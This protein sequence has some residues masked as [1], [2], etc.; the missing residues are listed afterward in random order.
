MSHATRL[1]AR[2]G[3]Q[4]GWAL[5]TALILMT[6]M[7]GASLT[8]V[9]YMDNET[10][11]GKVSRN[12]ETA[13]NLGEGALNAQVLA[14][15]QVW[16]GQA[17]QAYGGCTNTSTGTACPN[18]QQLVGRFPTSDAGGAVWTT[19]VRDN[20]QPGAPNFYSDSGTASAPGYD[21]NKDGLLWVR[22]SATA[23]GKTRTMVALVRAETQQEDSY[24]SALLS[25]RVD[26]QNNGNQTT[27]NDTGS[28][29]TVRCTPVDGESAPCAGYAYPLSSQQESKLASQIAPLGVTTGY[30]G[31][32]AISADAVERLKATAISQGNYYTSCPASLQGQLVGQIVYVD[33]NATCSYTGNTSYNTA[34][35]PGVLIMNQGTLSLGGGVT[36]YGIVYHANTQGTSST[37]VSLTGNS[38]VQGSVMVEGAGTTHIGSSGGGCNGGGN[39]SYAASAYNGLKS[40]G[41]AGIVQNTWRELANR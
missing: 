9:S 33:T 24:R 28:N 19:S 13:F 40:I 38:C 29:V 2:L 4:D 21:F 3:A 18:N 15:A 31:P 35:S 17:A 41:K 14:L 32:P 37:V 23:R 25:G 7:M 11:Q 1:R 22:A 6:I 5:V 12:R 10:Q 20:N 30:T 27:V 26:L 34:L 8:V 16:P 36:F 39:I